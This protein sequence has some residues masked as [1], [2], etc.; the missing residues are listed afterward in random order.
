MRSLVIL[1]ALLLNATAFAAPRYVR[2][3]CQAYFGNNGYAYYY[4]GCS[5]WYS[6]SYWNADDAKQEA[7]TSALDACGGSSGGIRCYV[8]SCNLESTDSYSPSWDC[9]SPASH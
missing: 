5:A 9:P 1:G 3:N 8:L 4:N 7:Q 2:Y 6:P